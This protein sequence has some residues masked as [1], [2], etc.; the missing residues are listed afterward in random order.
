MVWF[1]FWSLC[2]SLAVFSKLYVECPFWRC[3]VKKKD[4]FLFKNVIHMRFFCPHVCKYTFVAGVPR[5]LKKGAL[6]S[7]NWSYRQLNASVWVTEN[8]TRVLWKSRECSKHRAVSPASWSCGFKTLREFMSGGVVGTFKCLG[9]QGKR[10]KC[11]FEAI[12]GSCWSLV[13]SS[14]IG[15]GVSECLCRVCP[16]LTFLS[17]LALTWKRKPQFCLWCYCQTSDRDG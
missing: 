15:T 11:N 5:G 14:V 8:L 1:I 12:H 13:A 10:L 9:G 2:T 16:K 6:E 4:L 3:I 17:S 7:W